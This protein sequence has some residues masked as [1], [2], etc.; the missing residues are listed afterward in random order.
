VCG[1]GPTLLLSR[2]E[3]LPEDPRVYEPEQAA[4]ARTY[5]MTTGRLVEL[6][7]QCD[8]CG[9]FWWP[10]ETEHWSAYLTD[11]EPPELAFFCP[12]C[13][14]REFGESYG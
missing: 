3:R 6:I 10:L 2:A 13:S 14:E 12:E 1:R 11:D 8:E 4:R 5:V 7:P 9:R